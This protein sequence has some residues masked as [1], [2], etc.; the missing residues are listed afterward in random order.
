MEQVQKNSDSEVEKIIEKSLK[1][2]NKNSK[3]SLL[4]VDR[5]VNENKNFHSTLS[6]ALSSGISDGVRGTL[7]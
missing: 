4:K 2:H 6:K 7:S 1:D 3:D 5:L